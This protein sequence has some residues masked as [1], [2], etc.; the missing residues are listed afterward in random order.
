[1]EV[2]FWT[3]SSQLWGN[4]W[5]WR[6]MSILMAK[7]GIHSHHGF[8]TIFFSLTSAINRWQTGNFVRKM[9]LLRFYWKL[10]DVPIYT[11]EDLYEIYIHPLD[12]DRL[13][14][15]RVTVKNCIHFT[16]HWG[17]LGFLQLISSLQTPAICWLDACFRY[18]LFVLPFYPFFFWGG[19]C[20]VCLVWF[21]MFGLVCLVRFSFLL[22]LFLCL[23]VEPWILETH[24]LSKYCRNMSCLK[25]GMQHIDT[26]QIWWSMM[27]QIWKK[28]LKS[29]A[30][31]TTTWVDLSKQLLDSIGMTK[32]LELAP[33]TKRHKNRIACASWVFPKMVVPPKHPKMIIF[34][35]KT[36][37]CWVPPF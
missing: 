1:M 36:N 28:Q 25:H 26:T 34:S 17:F 2:E 31:D 14:E 9:H 16:Y 37:S 22:C 8:H 18:I 10:R 3:R 23:L 15:Y 6:N 7:N 24:Q 29:K 5:L 11:F 13:R 35:R 30:L 33:E 27:I 4:G 19:G 21:G 32:H 20:L 12:C